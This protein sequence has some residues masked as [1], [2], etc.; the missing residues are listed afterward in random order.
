MFVYPVCVAVGA[1]CVGLHARQAAQLRSYL[2]PCPS[3]ES[4]HT[5]LTRYC[6]LCC[7]AIVLGS[8]D[9]VNKGLQKRDRDVSTPPPVFISTENTNARISM[10]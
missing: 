10:C 4:N 8:L 2:L 9:S 6:R 7:S 1:A 3:D 5:L